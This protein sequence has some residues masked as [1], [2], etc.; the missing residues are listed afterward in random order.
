MS[1][2]HTTETIYGFFAEQISTVSVRD[3]LAHSIIYFPGDNEEHP[4]IID[5]LPPSENI[6]IRSLMEEEDEK[7]LENVLEDIE[8]W[9]NYI[10]FN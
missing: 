1:E 5:P 9:G 2:T 4:I 10:Y 8:N 3:P 7:A 6:I